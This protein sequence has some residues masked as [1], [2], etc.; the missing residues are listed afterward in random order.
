MRQVRRLQRLIGQEA[1]IVLTAAP[2]VTP[3]R[4]V[5]TYLDLPQG[6]QLTTSLNCL[7]QPPDALDSA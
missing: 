6:N 3:G 4:T 1:G 2:G 7:P 5:Q